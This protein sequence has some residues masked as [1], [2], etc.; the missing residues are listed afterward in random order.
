MCV[1]VF[2]VH[3]HVHL[4]HLMR[5]DRYYYQILA[6]NGNIISYFRGTCYKGRDTIS[7]NT[8]IC[9]SFIIT[10]DTNRKF[11]SREMN[12]LDSLSLSLVK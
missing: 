9:I 2:C 5:K 1:C 3:A 10:A 4:A 11:I 7:N 8:V 12:I 6:G